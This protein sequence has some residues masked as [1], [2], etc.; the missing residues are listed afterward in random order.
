MRRQ[1]ESDDRVDSPNL[2]D[3]LRIKDDDNNF[4]G[5]QTLGS[6]LSS[7]KRA[8]APERVP[9]NRTLLDIIRE[10]PAG[11]SNFKDGKKSWKH[12]KEKLRLRRQGSGSSWTS[13][14]PVPTS[15]VP[16]NQN[17]NRMISRRDSTRMNM[18]I[19]DGSSNMVVELTAGT[20]YP[21]TRSAMF[22]RNAS[23]AIDRG[24]MRYDNYSYNEPEH[25]EEE[26]EGGAGESTEEE[27]AEGAVDGE[28]DGGGGGGEQPVV[29]MS[30]MALL[31]ETDREMGIDGLAAFT[32]EDDDD[33]EDEEDEKGGAGAGGA[34][35]TCCVCM[36]RHKGAA[37][38]PCGHT[39]CRLCSR[40][41]WVQRGN[42]PLCNNF[43]LEILD[44]F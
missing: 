18:P 3:F 32:M 28:E 23:R 12:F 40:E 5:G 13:S 43:I 41:L 30:L 6:A 17:N 35:S 15:D 11:G 7:E 25:A 10:D 14:V 24:S 37:F 16:I 44:I 22:Q 2:R 9:S 20:G 27:E 8:G 34:Y 39:F 1:L 4:N 29:R 19:S 38:I 33:D 21:R 42:C 31:A 36:V 26:A